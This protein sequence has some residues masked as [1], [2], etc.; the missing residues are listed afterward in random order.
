MFSRSRKKGTK[1]DN[2]SQKQNSSS[3]KSQETED[4]IDLNGWEWS[5]E[6]GVYARL[7]ADGMS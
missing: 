1:G 3:S 2:R 4:A 6:Y 5:E 7:G